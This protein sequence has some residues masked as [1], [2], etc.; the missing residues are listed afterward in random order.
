VGWFGD[1]TLRPKS[2]APR[3]N[4]VF[5]ISMLNDTEPLLKQPSQRSSHRV[6]HLA[7]Q[8]LLKQRR[9]VSQQERKRPSED[10]ERNTFYLAYD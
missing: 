3:P 1:Q 7:A 10:R 8:V 6:N 9:Q 4:F 2:V 5:N